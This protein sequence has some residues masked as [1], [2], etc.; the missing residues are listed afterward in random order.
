MYAIKKKE[1]L[2]KSVFAMEIEAPLVARAAKPGQFIILRVDSEG[3]R[4]PLTVSATDKE[5]GTVRIVFA[6]V[7]ASTLKL[8]RLMEG[9]AVKDFAGP[10]GMPTET[11]GIS[12]ACVVGGGVGCAIAL[13]IARALKEK[14]ASVDS[15][16]GFRS[17]DLVILTDD[18]ISASDRVFLVTDDGSAGEAG[19]V[20]DPLERLLSGGEKYD[21]IYV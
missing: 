13:P 5:L 16:I 14:G 1:Q 21:M 10:L 8:S 20:T 19:R 7:G 6:A 17:S 11:D 2:N 12:K 15:V 18:F 3:E 9:E 4:I